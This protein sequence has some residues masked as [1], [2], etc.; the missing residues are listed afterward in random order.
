MD[1]EDK[2]AWSFISMVPKNASVSAT[3]D[4]LPALSDRANLKELFWDHY[5]YLDAD[6]IL[7]HD[8]YLGFGCAM[9]CKMGEE[10]I[11]RINEIKRSN[12]WLIVRKEKNFILFKRKQR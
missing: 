5:D 8:K 2:I 7:L 11:Q 6:Y 10:E 1:G 9:Y 12:H 3:G 4:L